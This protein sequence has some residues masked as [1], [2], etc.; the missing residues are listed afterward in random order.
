L[1]LFFNPLDNVRTAQV[2]ARTHGRLRCGTGGQPQ[3]IEDKMM[4]MVM[5]MM[6]VVVDDDDDGGG[7]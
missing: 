4:M 5:V 3:S 1:F 7:G 2:A 6:V